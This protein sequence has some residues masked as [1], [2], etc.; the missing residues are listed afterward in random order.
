M[1]ME[2]MII[3]WSSKVVPAIR[4]L[5]NL[6]FVLLVLV[7]WVFS[8]AVFSEFHLF[9][10]CDDLQLDVIPVTSEDFWQRILLQCLHLRISFHGSKIHFFSEKLPLSQVSSFFLWVPLCYLE[11]SHHDDDVRLGDVSVI[12]HLLR[13]PALVISSIYQLSF[14]ISS[15]NNQSALHL[16]LLMHCLSSD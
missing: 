9:Y 13:V 1:W 10:W 7:L 8:S 12:V 2:L 15:Q 3:F 5:S 11:L 4:M 16:A 14:W 6:G